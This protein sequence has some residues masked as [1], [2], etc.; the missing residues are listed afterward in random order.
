[1]SQDIAQDTDAVAAA[2]AAAGTDAGRMVVDAESDAVPA[3]SDFASTTAKATN[4]SSA[5]LQ[6]SHRKR[7]AQILRYL[8]TIHRGGGGGGGG[9]A[10]A[11]SRA[12]HFIGE[13][14]ALNE[15]KEAVLQEFDMTGQSDLVEISYD[16]RSSPLLFS[17]HDFQSISA[18]ASEAG[19]FP[20]P[21]FSFYAASASAN[22][23]P[24][25]RARKFFTG[26]VPDAASCWLR[27]TR[28]KPE[29]PPAVPSPAVKQYLESWAA[30]RHLRSYKRLVRSL[31]AL[32]HAPALDGA[33]PARRQKE[34]KHYL[35]KCRRY[36]KRDA[37]RRKL[38]PLY[39][40]LFE[41]AQSTKAADAFEELVLGL[42]NARMI[43]DDAE[44]SVYAINGPLLEIRVEVELAPDGALLVRPCEHTGVE[45]NRD[46]VGALSTDR[47]V[48]SSLHR[49][50]GDMETMT[51]SPGQ[52]ETYC[53]M[54]K[55]IAVEIS[56]GGRYV[57]TQ[58]SS[59]AS[60]NP[61]R[62]VNRLLVTD[63][64]CFYHR[65]KPCSVWA[66]D[67]QT[68]A[69]L[70]SKQQAVGS[71]ALLSTV[72]T[73]PMA[74]LSLTHGPNAL[75]G[76]TIFQPPLSTRVTS[77]FKSLFGLSSPSVPP[78]RPLFPLPSSASQLRIHEL[79]SE[80]A[81][82]VVVE[83]PPGCG[84][85]HAIAN[86]VCSYLAQGKRVLVT[87]K[88]APALSVLRKR[89]PPC[90]QELVVDVTVSE[91]RQCAFVHT[92]QRGIHPF[93]YL[94]LTL[95]FPFYFLLKIPG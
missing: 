80:G 41:I 31:D 39:N 53:K 9:G 72:Q 48:I 58:S 77:S 43:V 89:L 67:A 95:R 92:L 34:I 65:P 94:F 71:R 42:G 79:L 27:L 38:E 52:P 3:V 14:P 47:E 23:S 1:M 46:V 51:V 66:R 93:I 55:R 61:S 15:A 10:N 76:A 49:A 56:S 5:E 86:I 87:S 21:P 2:A 11:Q 78:E 75:Q 13:Y 85:T 64:W 17:L 12:D 83:G 63:A 19:L 91:V 28:I 45:L 59:Y 50:V 18:S 57:S 68:L 36:V 37:I 40:R 30:Q 22:T 70:V 24:T 26:K 88:G 44:G 16:A 74:S 32:A 90:I 6:A 69:D 62:N 33:V 54:L 60:L 82:A 81:P 20:S 73:P 8:A 4:L 29:E 35:K 7:L 84:K 25:A